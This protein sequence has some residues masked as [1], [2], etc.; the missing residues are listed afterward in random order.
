MLI[1]GAGPIGLSALEFAKVSGARVIVMDM[2]A[3]RLDFVRDT[4]GVTDTLVATGDARDLEAVARLTEGRLAEV[5]V[6]A[7]GSASSMARALE[8]CSFG[9]RLVYVGITPGD[10]VLPHA[11][12]MHRR[13]LT[14]LASRNAL[15]QDFSRIIRLIEDGTIDTRPWITHRITFGDAIAAFPKLVAPTSGVIKA[16]I[17]IPA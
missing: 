10:L 5:V 11:P 14:L 7:T 2:A 4:M 15:S 12:V 1:I 13:E 6:D 17:G 3:K 16:V 9:G 8:F